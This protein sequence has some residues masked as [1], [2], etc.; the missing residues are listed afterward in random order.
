VAVE[1][2]GVEY[3]WAAD[4]P[5]ARAPF[6]PL[7]VRN[8]RMSR[9]TRVVKQYYDANTA[10]FE[11]LGQG[12]ESGAIHRAVWGPGVRSRIESFHYVDHQIDAALR[13]LQVNVPGNLRVFDLGCGV[14][15]SLSWLASRQAIEGVGVTIS[16]VQAR[17]AKQR[18]AD[19]GLEHRL[20]CLEASYLELP[21]TLEPAHLAF[22]I[23][24]FIHSP[25]PGAFF[26][27]AARHIVPDGM[28]IICDDFLSP[29]AGSARTY[30]ETRI[31]E[32]F[33]HGWVGPSVISVES[34]QHA[35]AAAGFEPVSSTDLTPYL[36]L[37]RPRDRL[38]GALV[39]LGRHL[40]IPGYRWRSLKGGSAL[41]S[42]LREGLIEYRYLV[43]RRVT[44]P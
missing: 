31:I 2:P 12:A 43:W 7:S 13:A 10:A 17:R 9:Q 15:S 3:D 40:P 11:T 36:E 30:R 26:D 41:Q 44:N 39:A 38:I 42:A 32:E 18:F 35:A 22:A 34:A 24:S 20:R 37:G 4:A 19:L 5:E 29:R 21:E 8:S 14:G 33:S 6:L 23:E 25:S 16:S 27:A 1:S 28:L